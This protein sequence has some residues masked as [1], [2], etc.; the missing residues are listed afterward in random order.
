MSKRYCAQNSPHAQQPFR[1]SWLE[2]AICEVSATYSCL[3]IRGS[4]GKSTRRDI[5]RSPKPQNDSL[6]LKLLS[7]R[8]FCINTGT[9]THTACCPSTLLLL[10]KLVYL[11]TSS[12]RL[13]L[14]CIRNHS[15]FSMIHHE[16]LELPPISD[17]RISYFRS[18]LPAN[19]HQLLPYELARLE[20]LC[21][22]VPSNEGLLLPDAHRAS[23]GRT[24]T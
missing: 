19:H 7:S 18:V 14:V 3:G 2:K 22:F 5:I 17:L 20:A 11:P 10:C 16:S 15:V 9:P 23:T 1:L 6:L 12:P 21:T 8:L 4:R 13:C 24:R